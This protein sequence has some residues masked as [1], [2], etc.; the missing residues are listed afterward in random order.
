MSSSGRTVTAT[1]IHTC[2][3]SKS[4]YSLI[5]VS[6]PLNKLDDL[7]EILQENA[8]RLTDRS[9]M[10]DLIPFIHSQKVNLIKAEIANRPAS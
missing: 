1:S 3:S 4:G 9:H 8:L 7:R 6:I 5:K 2:V 10:S